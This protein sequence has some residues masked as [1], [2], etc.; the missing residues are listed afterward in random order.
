MPGRIYT[1]WFKPTRLGDY[2]ILCAEICG[3]GHGVMGAKL[4]VETAEQRATWLAA[5]APAVDETATDAT[6]TDAASTDATSSDST[7]A[8]AGQQ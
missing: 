4:V 2:D 8:A 7:S 3:I 6:A 5:H 1:G